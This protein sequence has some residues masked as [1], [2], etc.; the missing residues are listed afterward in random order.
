MYIGRVYEKIVAAKDIYA[1]GLIKIPRPELIVLYNGPDTDWDIRELK[2]SDAFE[3]ASA[4]GI[5]HSTPLQLEL[6]ATMYN[7]NQGHNEAMLRRS[8]KLNGYS[9][10]I[11]KAREFDRE[12]N[13]LSAAL[14]KAVEYCIGQNILREFL[15]AHASEVVNLLFAEWKDEEA[16]EYRYEE[17]RKDDAGLV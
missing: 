12:L 9:A 8:E 2:L 16:L 7:I 5:G 13:D 15:E 14:K 3:D 17:G 10:F 4:L 1:K 6:S 11:D